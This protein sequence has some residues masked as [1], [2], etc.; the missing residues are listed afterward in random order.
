MKVRRAA[1][2]LIWMPL[3][4]IVVLVGWALSWWVA[5]AAVA[6]FVVVLVPLHLYR[7]RLR[8]RFANDPVARK[9]YNERAE[10][11]LY[12]WAK[13]YGLF[14]AAALIGLLVLV[15]VVAATGGHE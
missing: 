7:G 12:R 14:M 15:A 6:Y 1:G 5:V 10:K 9:A 8:R 11:R 2:L 4:A 13:G 3:L